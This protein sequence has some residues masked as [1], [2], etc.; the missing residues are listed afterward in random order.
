MWAL[1]VG[2][3]ACGTNDA[4]EVEPAPAAETPA[5]TTAE[6]THAGAPFSVEEAVEASVVLTDPAGH[7][8][9]PVRITGELAEV[10]VRKGCWAVVRDDQGHSM[11]VTMKDHA[12]GVPTDSKGYACDIEG[13][14]VRKQVDQ[15]TL[16]HYAEEGATEHPEA[17]QT[18]AWELVAVAVSTKP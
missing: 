11:R 3:V 8:E 17:G 1:M 5:A 18:E 7:S 16:D 4:P 10:C 12:F 14:L 2:L 15:K 6:W 13:Q 9:S